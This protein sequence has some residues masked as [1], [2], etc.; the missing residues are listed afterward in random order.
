MANAEIAALIARLRTER[1]NDSPS[2]AD[3]ERA[4]DIVE[5]A[6]EYVAAHHDRVHGQPGGRGMRAAGAIRREHA[7]WERLA[8]LVAPAKEEG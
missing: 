7:A 3:C 6:A 2:F 4:A 1:G 8:A 5:A